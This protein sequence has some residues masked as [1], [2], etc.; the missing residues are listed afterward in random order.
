[1][2]TESFEP[3]LDRN[4]AIVLAKPVIDLASPILTETVNYATNAFARCSSSK[5]GS[6]EEAY[7]VLASYLHVIQ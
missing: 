1:M 7:P 5:K 6:T 4:T 3:I 2:P